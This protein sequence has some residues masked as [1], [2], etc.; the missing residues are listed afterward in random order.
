MSDEGQCE[1]HPLTRIAN[2]CV[3]D[4]LDLGRSRGVG[5]R[6][7]VLIVRDVHPTARR[8]SRRAGSRRASRRAPWQK[9]NRRV[10]AEAMWPVRSLI[11]WTRHPASGCTALSIPP[12]SKA[13]VRAHRVSLALLPQR[14]RQNESSTGA[15]GH[16]EPAQASQFESYSIPT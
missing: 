9:A 8:S 4:N 15:H 2:G 16:R 11:T 3:T 7:A 10:D 14:L 13:W 6:L 1:V 12:C 5:E